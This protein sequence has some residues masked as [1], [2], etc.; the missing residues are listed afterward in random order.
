M[1]LQ[2]ICLKTLRIEIGLKMLYFA[3][4][5]QIQS[6]NSFEIELSLSN[7]FFLY[8]TPFKTISPFFRL[9]RNSVCVNRFQC[10]RYRTNPQLSTH[11]GRF[12]FHLHHYHCLLHG[13]HL[14]WFCHCH[15]P[16][17]GRVSLQKLRA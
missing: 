11:C 16:V 15:L 14:R 8:M 1:K 9:A 6:W 7:P 3:L 4:K 10:R 12:L 17:R 2:K 5:A 13:Q